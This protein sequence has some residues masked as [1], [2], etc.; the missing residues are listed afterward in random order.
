M[1]IGNYEIIKTLGTGVSGLVVSA[2]KDNIKY[3]IK[4]IRS[5]SVRGDMNIND[6]ILTLETLTLL[7]KDRVNNYVEDFRTYYKHMEV[8]C[9]VMEYIEGTDLHTYISN[10]FNK[11][12]GDHRLLWSLIYG[13]V[14]GLKCIHENGFAHRDIKPENIMI[15]DDGEIKYID[16]GLSCVASCKWDKCLNTC[17]VENVGTPLF[18]SPEKINKVFNKRESFLQ[19]EQKNDIWSLG[20]VLYQLANG[21]EKYPFLMTANMNFIGLKNVLLTAP[22]NP[23]AYPNDDD[24]NIFINSI[25]INDASKRP[26][27]YLIYDHLTEILKTKQ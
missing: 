22:T 21:S 19:R 4:I 20:V 24:V 13:I 15:T 9:I 3:A 25:L 18:M 12:L 27:I 17:Y 7:C 8:I 2:S 16:F 14:S 11:L 10:N 5:R 6:E 26:D 1:L 23:S